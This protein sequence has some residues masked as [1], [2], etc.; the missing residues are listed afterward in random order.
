MI[1][2]QRWARSADPYLLPGI[3]AQ[4]VEPCLCGGFIVAAEPPNERVITFAVRDHQLSLRHQTW[5]KAGMPG[6]D[7][8]RDG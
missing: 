5:R 3:R 6:L 4:R 7:G 2:T 1:G 8:G